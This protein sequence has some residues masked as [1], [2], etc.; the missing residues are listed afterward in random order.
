MKVL[1]YDS[2][3]IS[4]QRNWGPDGRALISSHMFF[5]MVQLKFRILIL[6][7]PSKWMA[8]V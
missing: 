3:L 1:L 7:P 4:F 2:S 8:S 5:P 6:A